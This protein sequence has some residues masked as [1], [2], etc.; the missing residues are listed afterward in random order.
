MV[1]SPVV[2]QKYLNGKK[3]NKTTKTKEEEEEEARASLLEI[4]IQEV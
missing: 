4:P 2:H 3:Q 1:L